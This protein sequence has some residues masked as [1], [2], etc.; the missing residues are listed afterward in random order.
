MTVGIKGKFIIGYDGHEHRLLTDGV[1]VYEGTRIK[2]VGKTYTGTVDEWIDAST[3]LVTPGLIN[4]HLHAAGAP[5]DKSFLEDIG[6]RPL[7]GS[8]LG[9]NLT[10]LNLSTSREDK[11]TLARYSLA[12]CLRSGNTTVMEIGMVPAI[13]EQKTVDMIGEMGIRA[14]EGHSLGD[15]ALVRSDAY[16]FNTSWLGLDAG[17]ERLEKAEQFVQKYRGAHGG[18]LMPAL[19]PGGVMTCSY[20]YQ[21]AIREKSDELEVPVSIHAGEWMVEFQNMLR[22]YGRTPVEFM[23]DTGLLGPRLIVGHLWAI[24]GHPLVAYPAVGGGDLAL[25]AEAGATVS[26]DPV[27]FVKRGNRMHSHSRYL[28][29]GVNVSI[30]TDTVPQDML[31]EMRVASYVSKLADWDP[32]SGSSREVFNS[33][34]LAGADALGR[35][36][37]GRLAA[38]ALADIAIIDMQTINNVP[39]RDPV[40]NLVNCAQRGDVRTVIVDGRILVDGGRLLYVDEERLVREVQEVGERIWSRIPENHHQGRSVDEVSP[41]SFREWVE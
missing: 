35:S 27:V 7:Y 12:E 1:V 3:C 10:A 6:V 38:G 16:N 19:Y 21:K 9:E 31:N 30:G 2:H 4:T 24:A 20:E 13:G 22:M 18:R 23:H 14:C 26:H 11:E 33:A 36:D 40:R 34:T 8:N 28:A 32:Y 15:G 17:L 39:C 25:L 5:N 41:Q 29:A 37:L